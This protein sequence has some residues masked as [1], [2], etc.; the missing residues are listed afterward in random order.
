MK[1]QLIAVALAVSTRV[2]QAQ[3]DGHVDGEPFVAIN[4]ESYPLDGVGTIDDP[5]DETAGIGAPL[6]YTRGGKA[7]GDGLGSPAGD[8]RPSARRVMQELYLNSPL[9]RTS[10]SKAR[11]MSH[12][13]SYFGIFLAQELYNPA[14]GDPVEFFPIPCD[15]GVMD[16]QCLPDQ[17]TGTGEP[18]TGGVPYSRTNAVVGPD[19]VRGPV[20][21]ATAWTDLGSVY[22]HDRATTDSLLAPLDPSNPTGPRSA[23]MLLTENGLPEF[24][25]G[26]WLIADQ[27]RAELLGT[28]ALHTLLLREHNRF[29]DVLRDSRLAAWEV[30]EE[31]DPPGCSPPCSEWTEWDLFVAARMWTTSVFQHIIEDEYMPLLLGK[32]NSPVEAPE[33]PWSGAS[34]QIE[35]FA[36]VA[37]SFSYSTVTPTD[38]IIN[39]DYQPLGN[40]DPLPIHLGMQAAIQRRV[41]TTWGLGAVMRGMVF[42]GSLEVDA[43]HTE[44]LTSFMHAA[45][46]ANVQLGRDLGLPS[47]NAVR[48]AYNLPAVASFEDLT[49]ETLVAAKLDD[50]Y[51]GGIDDL[52]AIVGAMLEVHDEDSYPLPPLL[53]KA[54]SD[55]LTRNMVADERWQDSHNLLTDAEGTTLA[56]V[57]RL[58]PDPGTE[59]DAEYATLTNAA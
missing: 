32:E 48:E 56:D 34:A 28:L 37:M 19:G 49:G 10:G 31:L 27:R 45:P 59:S 46:T 14:A 1:F 12:A 3:G 40:D 4:E 17:C 8:G 51:P 16:M 43:G 9:V 13:F 6:L 21:A 26:R 38:R 20:N 57:I 54:L 53:R 36:A 18:S 7:F 52:D 25:D 33:A 22:G 44:E 42:Q 23:K 15:D 47:Y 55:Q 11:A 39:K 41:L 24:V 35:A 5:Q 29:V 30:S 50:L 58:N 2:K